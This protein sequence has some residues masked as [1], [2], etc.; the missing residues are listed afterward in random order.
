MSVRPNVRLHDITRLYW[1]EFC[2][3]YYL[4]VSLK[5]VDTVQVLLKSHKITDI[6]RKAHRTYIY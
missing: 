6:L 3:I 5:P 4:A 2:D 1:A